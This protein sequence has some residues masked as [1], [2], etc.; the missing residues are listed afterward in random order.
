MKTATWL[1]SDC[2]WFSRICHITRNFSA[3]SFFTALFLS[4]TLAFAAA[5]YVEI[6]G[7]HGEQSTPGHPDVMFVQSLTIAPD[8]FTIVKNVDSASPAIFTAVAQGTMFPSATA[9]LYSSTPGASP[10]GILTFQN[11]LATSYQ[12]QGGGTLEQASF[13]SSNPG[14]IFLELPGIVGESS[15]PGH[16]GVVRIDSFT[17]TA[18]TFSVVKAVDSISPALFSAVANGTSFTKASV[19][20]YN[21]AVPSGPP[22]GV[23]IFGNVIA[24]AY[25]VNG[26]TS[27]TDSFSF[28]TVE[29]PPTA[30]PVVRISVS[31][32]QI[33]EGDS[34]T[35]QITA[36]ANTI[37]P[38][39]L[40][41]AMSGKATFGVDYSLSSGL[42]Q[43]GQ[44]IIPLGSDTVSITLTSAADQVREK[45]ET[46]IMVLQRGTGYK[47]S[48]PKKAKIKIRNVR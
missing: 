39:V 31:P 48:K 22:D 24:S 32:A 29:Q 42:G 14:S 34:A 28:A 40:N 15:T 36:S 11:V 19:L 35:F 33:T 45:K 1:G 21:A 17:I 43:T 6:P 23:L 9:L 18:T 7:I 47:L 44:I 8:Q 12:V 26:G 41:Y 27:E 38:V 37:R 3:A 2:R 30:T 5:L 20:F 13:A 10:D 16:P 46:A 25:Q 4:P